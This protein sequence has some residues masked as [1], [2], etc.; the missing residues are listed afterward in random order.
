MIPEYKRS[1]RLNYNP[2]TIK[3]AAGETRDYE[4]EINNWR[5]LRKVNDAIAEI[6][7]KEL[8]FQRQKQGI[9]D[10]QKGANQ[11]ELEIEQ[12]RQIDDSLVNW[13]KSEGITDEQV[14]EFSRPLKEGEAQSP[15]RKKYMYFKSELVKQKHQIDRL[16]Q[17]DDAFS[18]YQKVRHDETN[19][20]YTDSALNSANASLVKIFEQYKND[21]IGFEKAAQPIL[22]GVD[23]YAPDDL[24]DPLQRAVKKEISNIKAKAE[25]NF[26][27]QQEDQINAS[28]NDTLERLN[29]GILNKV[30]DNQ[31]FAEDLN[32]V[33]E[34]LNAKVKRGQMTETQKMSIISKMDDDIAENKITGD[35][36]RIITDKR[37]TD[38][39]KNKQSQALIRDFVNDFENEDFTPAQREVIANK[40]AYKLSTYQTQ[41]TNKNKA[42]TKQ[43]NFLFDS[44]KKLFSTP[45]YIDPKKLN[46]FKEAAVRLGKELEYAQLEF[47][48]N[49]LVQT[50][51]LPIDQQYA[52]LYIMKKGGNPYDLIVADALEKQIEK[53]VELA[54][55][56]NG[57]YM[58]NHS[59]VTP[60][61]EIKYNDVRKMDNKALGKELKNRYKNK[62][63][64]EDATGNYKTLSKQEASYL[65]AKY[66]TMP[67]EGKLEFLDN[68]INNIGFAETQSVT[69]Q[70]FK[71]NP[72]S[73][74]IAANIYGRGMEIDKNIAFDILTGS[75]LRKNGLYKMSK[76]DTEALNILLQ[77]L[78]IAYNKIK[79]AQLSAIKESIINAVAAGTQKGADSQT[80]M[81]NAIEAVTFGVI[82]TDHGVVVAPNRN[83][84][85]DDFE[86]WVETLSSDSK[87]LEGVLKKDDNLVPPPGFRSVS[88]FQEALNDPET[89]RFKSIGEGKYVLQY[90]D[91]PNNIVQSP[92]RNGPLILDWMHRS[93]YDPKGPKKPWYTE[94]KF[95][96]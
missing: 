20:L 88:E 24:K 72:K 83:I 3:G 6:G 19:R 37:L 62:P 93:S 27:N 86:G 85:S 2:S 64:I 17:S 73:S 52:Q 32:Q 9:E 10:A 89:L 40:L 90:T 58:L 92:L 31:P 43:D 74:I 66:E 77:P 82:E 8:A 70:L 15:Q 67:A 94:T 84:S 53:N 63:Y 42:M 33:N 54:N 68:L 36:N 49:A 55:K 91:S 1:T 80:V 69:G 45:E 75:E 5:G 47:T 76:D 61:G 51:K 13:L 38:E 12:Y 56:D 60:D 57:K 23:D 59:V 81:E 39:Q 34:L 25:V 46:S 78:E 50:N 71:D 7:L 21:P 79:P 96:R 48:H 65:A 16:F 26:R 41:I 30:R 4:G 29:V 95:W 14:S 11:I 18:I 22:Q 35:F 44:A 87:M 28:I